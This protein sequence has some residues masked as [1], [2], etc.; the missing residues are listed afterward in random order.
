MPVRRYWQMEILSCFA[1]WKIGEGYLIFA[2]RVPQT[3]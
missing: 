2:L 1:V 3:E